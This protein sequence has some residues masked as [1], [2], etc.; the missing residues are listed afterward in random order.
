L[1]I[2]VL[3]DLIAKFFGKPGLKQKERK[4]ALWVHPAH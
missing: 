3:G 4:E 2:I 1:E